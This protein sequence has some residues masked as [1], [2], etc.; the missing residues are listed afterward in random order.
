MDYN[1]EIISELSE[2]NTDYKYGD[3]D[4]DEFLNGLD[5]S[6]TKMVVSTIPDFE[7]N[8]LLIKKVREENKDT[9]IIV[10]SHNLD[11]AKRLYKIGATYVILPH[12]LGGSYASKM[13]DDYQLD[14]ERFIEERENHLEYIEDK[15]KMGHEHPKIDDKK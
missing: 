8:M 9:I 3:V 7:T 10:T 1:P 5:F 4:E 2:E 15:K 13:I 6:K 12:F 14:M 11:E